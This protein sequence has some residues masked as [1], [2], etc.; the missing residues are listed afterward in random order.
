ML[1]EA[2]TEYKKAMELEP[3]YAECHNN[4]A[5]LYYHKKDFSKAALHYDE[6]VKYGAK[7]DPRFRELLRPHKK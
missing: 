6:A 3:G 7:P 5:V 4:L 1:E 2:V